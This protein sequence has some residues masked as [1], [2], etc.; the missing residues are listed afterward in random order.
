MDGPEFTMDLNAG[1]EKGM[2]WILEKTMQASDDLEKTMQDCSRR[3][4]DQIVMDGWTGSTLGWKLPV[5]QQPWMALG[6]AR[7][8]AVVQES[9]AS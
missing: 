5:G 4:P 9:T 3:Q 7:S 1:C 6:R 8:P 2:T